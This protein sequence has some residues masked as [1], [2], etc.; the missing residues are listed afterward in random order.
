MNMATIAA[1]PQRTTRADGDVRRGTIGI[2]WRWSALDAGFMLCFRF[3][4]TGSGY[5]V[6][7]L[8]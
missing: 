7:Y 6:F 4:K 2:R 5:T 1:V 8:V 3:M